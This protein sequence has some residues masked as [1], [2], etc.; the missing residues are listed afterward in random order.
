MP[1]S[2]FDKCS[3]EE[4]RFKFATKTLKLGKGRDGNERALLESL[5]PKLKDKEGKGKDDGEVPAAKD[6]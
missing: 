2:A 1:E 6:K 4:H 5:E 3:I